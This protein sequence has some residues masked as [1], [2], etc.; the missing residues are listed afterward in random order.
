MAVGRLPSKGEPSSQTSVLRATTR[1]SAPQRWCKSA[2]GAR[3]PRLTETAKDVLAPAV[4]S[5]ATR[6]SGNGEPT[7]EA[8]VPDEKMYTTPGIY[9]VR[10][11]H[12]AVAAALGA[13][14]NMMPEQKLTALMVLRRG[15]LVE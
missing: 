1:E 2:S 11:I 4:W 14:C 10:S 12:Y 8:N 6:T 13:R 9:P 15:T 7:R 5:L 3:A